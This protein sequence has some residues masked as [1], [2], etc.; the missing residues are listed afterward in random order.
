MRAVGIA[1]LVL[2]TTVS[3]GCE[4]AASERVAASAPGA[5]L[6]VTIDTMRAD[7]LS[8][9]GYG[10]PTSTTLEALAAHGIRFADAYCTMPTTDPSHASILTGLYP[11]THGILRNAGGRI[12]NRKVSTLGTW[13]KARGYRTGAVTARVHLNPRA[14]GIRGF[15][16]AD[17]PSGGELH[18]SYRE[19][20]KRVRAWL[21]EHRGERWFLWAHLWEPHKPYEPPARMRAR[22]LPA[23]T[24]APT[25]RQSDPPRYVNSARPIDKA[26]VETSRRLYDGELA[27]ADAALA[28]LVAAAREFAPR[29]GNPLI[30]VV[31]DHGESL[32]E[33]QTETGIGFGH[34]LLLYDEV[35]KVPW[36]IQW[37][38]ELH[39]L[40]I[41]TAVSLVDL[42]PTLTGLVDPA[43]P[44]RGDGRNLAAVVRG[45][46]P[47]ALQ[48]IVLERRTFA[49]PP[50]PDL[51]WAQAAWVE[52]PWKL[53]A[54][55]GPSPDRLYNLASDPGERRDLATW[56]P[57]KVAELAS[58]LAAW[59]RTHR[60]GKAVPAADAARR[61]EHM[62]S[63]GYLE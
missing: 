51:G 47:P 29:H 62:R 26:V 42:A 5:V 34:G 48:P 9:Y 38:G 14:L 31:G 41:G 4:R 45:G 52:G 18:R 55:A 56:R 32:A 17:S 21:A 8:A 44:L 12:R 22:F 50:R 20:V 58:K 2:L 1:A 54:D 3:V 40:V 28:E 19:V 39:P 11:R 37:E 15:D 36:V 49:R 53:I 43:D 24:A 6:L 30:V 13:F 10:E 27:T 16:F 25:R 23:G 33:R 59:K 35:V 63:L 46:P 61:L 57:D 60:P 7:H